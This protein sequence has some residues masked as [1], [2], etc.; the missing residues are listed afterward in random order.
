MNNLEKG[1]TGEALA[2]AYLLNNGYVTLRR[3]YRAGKSEIDLIMQIGKTVVFVEVKS[4]TSSRCGNA[5]EAINQKK[6]DMIVKGALSFCMENGLFESSMRFD[7]IEVDLRT[8]SVTRHVENAFF[9]ES[10]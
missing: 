7:A 5:L 10:Q 4:R 1:S 3:N 9:A 6:K 2:E 8:S